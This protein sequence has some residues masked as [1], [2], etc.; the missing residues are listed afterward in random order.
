MVLKYVATALTA[1]MLAVVAVVGVE[2]DFRE[3]G[4]GAS[5]G[6]YKGG[7]ATMWT[8]DFGDR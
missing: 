4:I 6:E 8:A 7:R 2:K 3:I 1:T 5:S